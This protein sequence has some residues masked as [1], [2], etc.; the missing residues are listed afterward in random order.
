MNISL[1]QNLGTQVDQE[2]RNASY[3]EL[4][5]PEIA[6]NA[7]K[8]FNPNF[9]W[10]GELFM[11]LLNDS[12]APQNPF[13]P[14]SDLPII[15]YHSA[16][17]KVEILVWT[18]GTTSIHQH[19]FG[20][21]F[22]VL[23]GSSVHCCYAFNEQSRI[24]SHFIQGELCSTTVEYLKTNSVVE[25]HSGRQGLIHRLFHLESPSISL[26]IRDHAQQWQLPQY[27][28]FTFGVALDNFFYE[29]D[30]S[31]QIF[32]R[33]Y[34]TLGML[35]QNVANDCLK[36]QI[37]Q[38]DFPRIFAWFSTN[39][40]IFQNTSVSSDL[41]KEVEKSHGSMSN[42]VIQ[43]A[44]SFLEENAIVKSRNHMASPDMRLFLG[45]L[46]N[47]QNKS[48]LFALISKIYPGKD[49]KEIC[50]RWLMKLAEEDN[51]SSVLTDL[52]QSA[53]L[54]QYQLSNAMSSA[55]PEDM[56]QQEI[57]LTLNSMMLD[58]PKNKILETR[59]F[60][61]PEKVANCIDELRA[62]PELKKLF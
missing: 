43:L 57:E 32:S 61:S 31:L 62:I 35:D 38:F 13:D 37:S 2:Y 20:G 56:S 34:R 46:L 19:G 29:A 36:C 53:S 4:R 60:E 9:E 39:S 7:L 14:F 49:S 3:D 40:G 42:L 33:L 28:Y 55:I 25:I 54:S 52:V 15:L 41:V 21:A 50:Q 18:K 58:I 24:N 30:D 59:N 45:L 26:L 11:Q 48:E 22:K 16:S 23:Q 5:L 1:F 44:E 6:A 17:I 27:K 12:T 51:V 8:S 47:V 10:S